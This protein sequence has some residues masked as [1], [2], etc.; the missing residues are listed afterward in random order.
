MTRNVITAIVVL[1]TLFIGFRLQY[2]FD[3]LYNDH[4]ALH[5]I[6]TMIQQSQSQGPK[7]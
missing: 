3:H 7:K 6:I 2:A 5:A 1:I 4:K